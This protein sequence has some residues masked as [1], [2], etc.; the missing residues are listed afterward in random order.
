MK[1][2]VKTFSLKVG[3]HKKRNRSTL[4]REKL[5]AQSCPAFLNIIR[6]NEVPGNTWWK[7]M[8]PFRG[9]I[10]IVFIRLLRLLGYCKDFSFTGRIK[11]R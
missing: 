7:Q 6:R 9:K 5:L 8:E 11:N 1:Y 10:I 3:A 2:P 4:L